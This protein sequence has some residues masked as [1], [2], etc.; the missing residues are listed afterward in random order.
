MTYGTAWGIRIVP[1]KID[2]C[3]SIIDSIPSLFRKNVRKK[4]TSP[5][6]V[7][8]WRWSIFRYRFRY[9]LPHRSRRNKTTQAA[10]AVNDLCRLQSHKKASVHN[11]FVREPPKNRKR[12]VA[13]KR[14]RCRLAPRKYCRAASLGALASLCICSLKSL[15][16]SAAGGAS[17]F[18]PRVIRPPRPLVG[19]ITGALA[20]DVHL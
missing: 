6:P 4:P 1:S 2:K 20:Q 16:A 19:L 18:S 10:Q 8:A 9:K 3:Q 5:I 14:R 17:G 15:A 11:G 12:L 7:R 13:T